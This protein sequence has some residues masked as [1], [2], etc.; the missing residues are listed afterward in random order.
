MHAFSSDGPRVRLFD[1][2][3]DGREKADLSGVH[4]E[5]TA[6]LLALW[7]A[8]DDELLPYPTVHPDEI[9]AAPGRPD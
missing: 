3:V 4:P 2:T 1:V 8:F 7:Q 6:E 9:A 5:L